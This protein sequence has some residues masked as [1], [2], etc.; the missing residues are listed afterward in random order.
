[1]LLHKPADQKYYLGISTDGLFV[2]FD[3]KKRAFSIEGNSI[4]S[5]ET[6]FEIVTS[7]EELIKGLPR[8]GARV[9]CLETRDYTRLM[10]ETKLVDFSDQIDE[11]RMKK[12][13]DELK[14]IKRACKITSN[15]MGE[16][17]DHLKPGILESELE[18][19][20]KTSGLEESHGTAF[21]FIIA[22]GKNSEM[23]HAKLKDRRIRAHDL[24]I[25]DIGFKYNDYCADMTRTFCLKP[26]HQQFEKH[27][28]IMQ[29]QE[30]AIRT[31]KK[32]V[33]FKDVNSEVKQFLQKNHVSQFMP[34]RV[35]HGIGLEVHEAPFPEN[36]GLL[37]SGTCFTLE[38]GIH[39]PG[40]GGIRI[41]D[42][43][44]MRAKA[45]QL[46][47]APRELKP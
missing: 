19:R 37:P 16:V 4:N 46:T 17:N 39:I 41:E 34:Y 31:A 8:I 11:Q 24:V 42:D 5:Y 18:R 28:L 7:I 44:V 33:K 32:N 13:G 27:A 35:G 25:V 23:V 6:G 9:P 10:N 40:F 36:E 26:N 21:D 15:V 20:L 12:S 22:S 38:P 14:N 45:K 2:F 30:I 29:A 1:M 3:E 43:F 47:D